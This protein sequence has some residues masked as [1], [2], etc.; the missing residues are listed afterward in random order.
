[1][2][3]NFSLRCLFLGITVCVSYINIHMYS[4]YTVGKFNTLNDNIEIFLKCCDFPFR[5]I[6]VASCRNTPK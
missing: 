1:M 3:I 5:Y 6:L 2:T 4:M